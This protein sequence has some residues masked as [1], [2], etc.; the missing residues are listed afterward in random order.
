MGMNCCD[1]LT[2]WRGLYSWWPG[3]REGGR[4]RLVETK[5]FPETAGVYIHEL[6]PTYLYT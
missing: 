1:G 6:L 3:G 5:K 2:A 4:E